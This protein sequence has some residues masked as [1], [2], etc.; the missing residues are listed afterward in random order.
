MTLLRLKGY[1]GFVIGIQIVCVDFCQ[2]E[3]GA[4]Q[5]LESRKFKSEWKERWC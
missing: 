3:A 1:I 4:I 5:K 2:W